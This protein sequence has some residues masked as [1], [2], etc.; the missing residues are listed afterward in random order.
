MPCFSIVFE[1]KPRKY[2][3][4]IRMAFEG[5]AEQPDSDNHRRSTIKESRG[6]T[7]ACRFLQGI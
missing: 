7:A 1:P 3:R 6:N 5:I 2:L 4:K